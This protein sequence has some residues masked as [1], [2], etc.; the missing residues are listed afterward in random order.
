VNNLSSDL[1]SELSMATTAMGE[2]VA[3]IAVKPTTT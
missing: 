1:K 3:A 2:L